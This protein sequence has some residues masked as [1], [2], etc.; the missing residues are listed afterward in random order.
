[1]KQVLRADK[2]SINLHNSTV[3]L[4]GEWNIHSYSTLKQK[5]HKM[6]LNDKS[7]ITIDGTSITSID[8]SG[9]WL[10]SQFISRLKNTSIVNLKG[11]SKNQQS[12]IDMIA[13]PLEL[14]SQ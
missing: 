10:I 6:F 4:C 5:L 13:N 11:F 8:T 12:L 2:G 3:L 14:K 9:A 1:M 7:H